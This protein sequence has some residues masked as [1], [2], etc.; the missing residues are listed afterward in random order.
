V[1]LSNE[2]DNVIPFECETHK[3]TE[4]GRLVRMHWSDDESG[5]MVRGHWE[6]R[7][8]TYENVIFGIEEF[9]NEKR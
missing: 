7:C 1:T 8:G 4:C 3:C 6:C 2:D 5:G 9:S